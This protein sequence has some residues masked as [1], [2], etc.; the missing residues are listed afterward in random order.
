MLSASS[1]YSNH[2]E[3][4]AA[5]SSHSKQMKHKLFTS[6]LLWVSHCGIVLWCLFVLLLLLYTDTFAVLL[7]CI[8][9]RK[10]LSTTG[11]QG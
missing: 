1:R 11:L 2:S 4:E 8:E 6:L 7:L 5:A 10:T 9:R 3:N